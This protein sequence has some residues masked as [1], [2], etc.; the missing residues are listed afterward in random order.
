MQAVILAGG[1]G[2]RLGLNDI[3]KPMVNI[4]GKPLLEHQI[5]LAKKY[6]IKDFFILS[7]HLGHVIK[8]YFG[9][10][11][12]WGVNIEHIIESKP[13]GTAGALKLLEGK[14]NERFMVFYGDIVMDFDIKSFINVDASK[15]SI[16]T[17]LVHP[18]DHPYDSDL[19]EI[20]PKGFVTKIIPKPHNQNKYYQNLVNAAVSIIFGSISFPKSCF[21]L[22]SIK[23]KILFEKI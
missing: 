10:G 19:V 6:G 15:N 12:K 11:K 5:L 21:L 22:F 17:I 18:N 20:N 2:T 9:D 13:L 4:S 3:P 14:I 7:G 1:K 16:G 23:S 8:E